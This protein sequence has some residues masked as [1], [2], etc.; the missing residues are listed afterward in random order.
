MANPLEVAIV[1]E[2]RR[3][4]EAGGEIEPFL[5][6]TGIDLVPVDR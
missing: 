5:A 3:G 2:G 6:S 4:L 1:V